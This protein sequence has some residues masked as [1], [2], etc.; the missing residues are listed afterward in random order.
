MRN[1]YMRRLGGVLAVAG[2][3]LVIAGGPALAADTVSAAFPDIEVPAGGTA[4][5]PLGPSLWSTIGPTRLT[6]VKVTYELSGV[7]GVRIAPSGIGGGECGT[8]SST[9]VVCTDPRGLSFEGETVE[10]YLPVVVTATGTAV[11]GDAG[12]VTITFSADGLTP[13]AG[14]SEVRV[15]G[16][17]PNLPITGP[18]AP[19]TGAF[20]LLL[21]AAGAATVLATRR[22]VRAGA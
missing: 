20:G 8:S 4:V 1:S 17:R 18:P 9:R 7:D 19:L 3:L 12:T 13:I 22:P 6:G 21:V 11:A 14:D 2:V 10:Q 16:D 5:D 15:A